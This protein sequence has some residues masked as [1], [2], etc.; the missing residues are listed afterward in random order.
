[1]GDLRLAGRTLRKTP[2]ASAV[3]VITLTL[4]I[5][6]NTAIF[7]VVKAV[8]LNPLPYQDANRLVTLAI[9]APDMPDN[10][11][12]DALTPEDWRKRSRSVESLSIYGD[13]STVMVENG[14]G[15]IVRGLRVNS[16]FFD[17]LGV[18]M[19]LGRAF[20]PEEDR[21]DRRFTVVILSHGFWIRRFGG[22]PLIVG[23]VVELSGFHYRVTGVLAANFAP[24]LHGTTELLPEIYMPAGVDYGSACR[25]CLGPHAIA[26]LKPGVSVEA[27]RSELAA[28]MREI[29]RE[30]PGDYHRD[31]SIKVTPVRD[32]LFGRVQ[33]ALW[34][35]WGGAGVVLLIACANIANLLLARATGRAK[36]MAIRA[37]LGAGRGR[38]IRQL[39]SE[40]AVLATAGAAGG[41]LLALAGTGALASAL[42]QEIPRAG[43]VRTDLG[44][45]GFSLAVSLLTA[46]LC[47]LAPAWHSARVDLNHAMKTSGKGSG[48]RS[49]HGVRRLLV[50]G[51]IALAT[52]LVCGALL[53]AKSFARLMNVDPGYDPGNVLTLSSNVWGSRYQEQAAQLQYYQEALEKLRSV[54]GL[55]GAAWTS[56]LPLDAADRRQMDVLD[57]NRMGDGGTPAR[58]EM[59]SVS[60]DYFHV[61]K[62]PLKRGRL[63]NEYD[64]VMTPKVA[65]ISESCARK[66][67]PG[68][69]PIGKQ[70]RLADVGVRIIVGVVGDIRQYGLDRAPNM[71]AYI[72]QAQDVIIG[73]YR[74]VARTAGPP[75]RMGP[76][77]RAVFGSVDST[78]PVYHIKSMEEYLAGTLAPRTVAL[79][80]LGFFAVLALVLAA[81]G[82]YSVI[83]F[84]VEL[85][86]R[87]VGIRMALGARRGHVVALIFGQSLAPL[88]LGLV[89]G[90]AG[91]SLV[92]RL[93]ASLLYGV[94]SMGWST[95]AA[96]ISLLAVVALAATIGPARRATGADP[97]AALREE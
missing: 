76:S 15:E 30:H 89:V 63:F 62:I 23:R 33:T 31:A 57:G 96:A 47:G 71:E 54:P 40:S 12:V 97:M 18:K 14:Q 75:M 50:A 81:A 17:T 91:A 64:T 8:L 36:E 4:A 83:S 41:L 2:A 43:D 85:R 72:A 74:L 56:M 82:I 13:A 45:L 94:R 65:L 9:T 28:V 22:D 24:L 35:V 46:M 52:I 86:A 49:R 44:V 6:A 92:T 10:Q 79:V 68:E 1:M 27:A 38:L 67:F 60:P 42:Q 51:E 93:L 90:I 39:L 59:Y 25:R 73:F 32:F 3:A 78:L 16:N 29:V 20:L 53:L 61:M 70:I 77:I 88:G 66:E 19:Q 34:A 11:T 37:A 84:V 5:G 21:P 87:E 55:K 48:D 7:S 58:V 80:L 69:D 95:P 26:R